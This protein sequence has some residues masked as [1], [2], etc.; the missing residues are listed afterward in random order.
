MAGFPWKNEK[1]LHARGGNSGEEDDE[2]RRGASPPF[3]YAVL[4][5]SAKIRT[6]SGESSMPIHLKA[7]EACP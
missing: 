5:R 1:Y 4:T 6:Y 3:F 7:G 2:K